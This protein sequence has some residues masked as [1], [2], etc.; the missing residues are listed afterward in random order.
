[1]IDFVVDVTN[2]ADRRRGTYNLVR[3]LHQNINNTNWTADDDN[4]AP[5]S[6]R[7]IHVLN[8]FQ[9]RSAGMGY[10]FGGNPDDPVPIKYPVTK[11]IKYQIKYIKYQVI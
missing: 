9:V 2:I 11:Y 7:E 1:M 4:C 5:L 3:K 6:Q 8:L 10:T